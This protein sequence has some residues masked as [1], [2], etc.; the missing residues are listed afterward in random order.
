VHLTPC[1]VLARVA[2]LAY[3]T[4]DDDLEVV[5]ARRLAEI[6]SP[7]AE[8]D[9][10]VEPGVHVRDGFAVTLWTYYGPLSSPDIGPA[11]YANALA[12]L[13]AGLRQIDVGAPHFTDRVEDAQEILAD[14]QQSP[15]LLGA[16][17]EPLTHSLARLA[18]AISGR[19]TGEQLLHGEPHVGN[20]L[21][22]RK[23]L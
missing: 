4:A 7:V 17:R 11:E 15:T 1:D 23:G 19:E 12:R 3:Q 21:R 8:L 16:D 10:R 14:R 6:G 18:I 5:V 13:H 20:V 9:P 22:T 2:P